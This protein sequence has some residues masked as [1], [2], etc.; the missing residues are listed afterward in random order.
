MI[1]ALGFGEEVRYG[2]KTALAMNRAPKAVEMA[3]LLASVK[4]YS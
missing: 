3:K 1:I 4:S 2:S